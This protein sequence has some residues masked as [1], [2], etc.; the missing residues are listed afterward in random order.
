M[1]KE[2]LTVIAASLFLISCSE[3]SS[4]QENESNSFQ[5]WEL[6]IVDSIQVDYLGTVDGAEFNEGKGIIFNF[7]EN[8]LIQFDE[9]GK[10]LNEEAYPFEGPGKVYYPMQLKNTTDGKLYAA[11]FVGWLYEFNPNLTFKREIEL[12]F[13]TEAKDGGGLRRVLDQWK[14]H[15]I[16][17]YPGR[18]GA[19]PYDPFF[20][21]DHYLLEKVDPQTGSA[22]PLIRIPAT[23]RF[24]SDKFYERPWVNFGVLGDTLYLTL[25]NEPL[26]HL[27]DLANNAKF[28][29]TIKFLPSKFEDNGEHKEAYQYISGSEMLDG[30]I[31]QFF[32][33]NQGIVLTFDEGI[34]A[35][36]FVQNNLKDPK[37]FPLYPSFQ[38]RILKIA[39]VDGSL[40][41][42]I[43]I[44]RSIDR[45][46]SIK[47]LEEPFYALRNDEY[48]GEEEDYLTFY[49]LRLVQK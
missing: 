30:A 29:K 20:F 25:D 44:P 43:I 46:L 18:D 13:I 17:Y 47:S 5:N 35:D 22:E 1:K 24:D 48:I 40:S 26:V 6:V 37:N 2:F 28:L 31:K 16:L 32:A 36:I 49:K 41:N 21:K 23:S 33:T 7:K 15:L 39:Q 42:E 8:K 11:S 3:S 14:N 9:S 27:Y 19:N 45:I 4:D 38:N 34:T 12:P 10:I